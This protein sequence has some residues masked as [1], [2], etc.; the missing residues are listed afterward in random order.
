MSFCYGAFSLCF[1]YLKNPT[2]FRLRGER[3]REGEKERCR[4]M[5][6]LEMVGRWV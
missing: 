4:E 3:K 1:G 5:S 2:P 6:A